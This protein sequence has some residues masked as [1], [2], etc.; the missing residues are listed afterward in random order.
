MDRSK[1]EEKRNSQTRKRKEEETMT[2][3]KAMIGVGPIME[4]SITYFEK[5]TKN[6]EKARILAVR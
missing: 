1:L 4:D 3:M 6:K 5:Q 2:K